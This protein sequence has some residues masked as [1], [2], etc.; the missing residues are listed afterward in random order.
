M[1]CRVSEPSFGALLRTL[2]ETAR[3]SQEALAER[4]T[5]S[6]RTVSDLERGVNKTARRFTADLLASAL[7]LQGE[8]HDR[9]V[10]AAAGRL[11]STGTQPNAAGDQP[12]R[13]VLIG[14]EADVEACQRLLAGGV[15]LLTLV[16]PG[17][18]GKT[19]LSRA[20]L[21]AS[22]PDVEALFIDLSPLAD[23]DLVAS[24]VARALGLADS[25]EPLLRD[26]ATALA[27]KNGLVVL[28]NAEHLLEPVAAV[29][30]ALMS[31]SLVTI[32]T[33]RTP[34][35]LPGEQVLDVG[36]LPPDR[37][38]E[39]FAVRAAAV[40]GHQVEESD[41]GVVAEICRR[42]DRLPLP[43]ELAA[44]RSRLLAPAELLERLDLDLLAA[45]NAGVPERQRTMRALVGWSYDLLS[46]DEQAVFAECS[47]FRGGFDH[48]SA[49]DVIGRDCLDQLDALLDASLLTSWSDG[50]RPRLRMLETVAEYAGECLA[51]RGETDDVRRRHVDWCTALAR[52]AAESLTGPEQAVWLSRLE[53]EHD[54]LRS[55]L[56]EALRWTADPAHRAVRIAAGI[57]RF[58]YLHGHLTEGRRWLDHVLAG[59]E[60]DTPEGQVAFA[61]VQYGAGVLTWL[62]GELDRAAVL[63]RRASDR[64][65]ELGEPGLAANAQMLVGMI[66]QYRGDSVAAGDQ[67]RAALEVGRGLGDLRVVAVALINLGTLATDAG[68]DASG[69]RF[70]QESLA[71][72]RVLGDTRSTADVL[73]SLGEIA[74]RQGR[75][76]DAAALFDQCLAAF[77][78]L[79]DRPGESE[80][81]QALARLATQLGATGDAAAQWEQVLEISTDIGDP[82]GRAA[83]RTGLAVL[84]ERSE[85][86]AATDRYI[87]ALDLN[88][89]LDHQAGMVLCLEGLVR[90]AE[91][92][93]DEPAA[94]R[95]RDELVVA[96]AGGTAT[97]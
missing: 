50:G 94:Q 30:K 62:S 24:V 45:R 67:F 51:A 73:G 20:L 41:V 74:T 92:T 63:A 18:V 83:A 40:T 21:D 87:H 5:L 69:E 53:I 72:F 65:A 22:A 4:A 89:D 97:R 16:G 66:A 6:T 90:I 34:L 58:W 82:W 38:V 7:G 86:R 29:A 59:P 3:L 11:L 57:W 80:C 76:D 43:I 88:R 35:R 77:R 81:R 39:L 64:L 93:A 10:S 32:V 95:W 47:V 33:S 55:A 79:G 70:L 28:D 85:D 44:A 12:R 9:F 84:A 91:Q 25:P 36:P 15:Q 75:L 1:L 61:T 68:D 14:R 60:P 37:A 13:E 46:D 17:G 96:R 26:A 78:E 56:T 23:P 27:E 54:N 8:D 52:R 42:L 48:A 31:T 19:R 2:R 49:S 71:E